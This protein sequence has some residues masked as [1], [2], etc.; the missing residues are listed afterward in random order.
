M[1]STQRLL[2]GPAGRIEVLVDQPAAPRGLAL[3]AHPHPLGGGSNT[4]KVVHTLA[5]SFLALGY[6]C[7]R[8]NFRGVGLSE[9]VHD[10][11]Q[12]E[13]DDLLSVLDSARP[14]YAHL[15]LI[16]AGYSFGAY[17]QTHVAHRLAD[18]GQPAERLVLVGTAAGFVEG[19]R[20]Y[21]TAAVP[22]NTLVIHGAEDTTVP[23]ANVFAW[24]A[25]LDLPVVVIPG[26][27]HFFHRRLHLIRDVV[28]RSWKL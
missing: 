24:A 18:A 23:L 14:E 19:N 22:A 11:G 15:P 28:T 8:P 3:I 27:D 26:A 6:A 21:D 4:N 1:N 7:W 9:G 13:C 10:H 17:C 25:P 16:L 20:R 12:G 5:R 2:D